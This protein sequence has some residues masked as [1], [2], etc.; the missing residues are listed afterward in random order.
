MCLYHSTLFYFYGANNFYCFSQVDMVMLLYPRRSVLRA[1]EM[2]A[3]L[4]VQDIDE[5]D[6]WHLHL[7]SRLY[8]RPRT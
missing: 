7:I 8:S 3:N 4:T 1:G 5:R 2:K 6:L